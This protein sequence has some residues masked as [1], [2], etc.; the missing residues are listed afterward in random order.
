MRRL[1]DANRTDKRAEIS[2]DIPDS[3]NWPVVNGM[4]VVGVSKVNEHAVF[5]SDFY[6]WRK[7]DEKPTAMETSFGQWM[8]TII[9]RRLIGS[10][11]RHLQ[12][13]AKGDK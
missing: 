4:L 13:L 12:S 9:I 3:Y 2:F 10:G 5:L 6:A 7:L 1:Q 8:H 11:V